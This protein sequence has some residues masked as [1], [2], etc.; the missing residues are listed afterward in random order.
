MT[1]TF[2]TAADHQHAD[3]DFSKCPICE[4]GLAVCKVCNGAEGQLTKEC[5]G[6]ALR[7]DTLDA[8][9]DHFIDFVDGKW[10]AV[11]DEAP[12]PKTAAHALNLAMRYYELLRKS[13]WTIAPDGTARYCKQ[14]YFLWNPKRNRL[15]DIDQKE[16][17][18]D[19]T[20]TFA[21]KEPL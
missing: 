18:V 14:C 15:G 2:F 4:D 21:M 5:C 1:H 12:M 17:H 3:D 20:W 10:I 6:R 19:C 7:S 11:E 13:E 16:H 9:Y 8:I